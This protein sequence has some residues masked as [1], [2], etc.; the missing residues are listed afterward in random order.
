MGRPR[1]RRGGGILFEL[2]LSIALFVGA[3]SFVLGS[4]KSVFQRLE[5]TAQ[6]QFALDLARSKLAELELGLVTINDL[7]E[8][9]VEG[10][11]SVETFEPPVTA[12]PFDPPEWVVDVET[13]RS[14]FRGLTLVTVR[15]RLETF[16]QAPGTFA[17]STDEALATIRQLVRLHGED[18]DEFL[19]D[20]LLDGLPIEEASP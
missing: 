12:G 5:R 10:L 14:S 20:D 19:E 4:L 3:G 6:S 2:L 9:V 18:A 1:H 15:V 7:H 11:G 13:E 17:G 8:E 16:D